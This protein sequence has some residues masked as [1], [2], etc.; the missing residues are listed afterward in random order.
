M[1]QQLISEKFNRLAV[2][3]EKINTVSHV[4]KNARLLI[5]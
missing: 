5:C 2:G 1:S 4:M 3:L